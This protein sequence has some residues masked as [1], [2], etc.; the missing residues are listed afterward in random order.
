MRAQ[1]KVIR[2]ESCTLLL[3]AILSILMN[4]D[5]LEIGPLLSQFKEF[6][7]DLPSDIKGLA[8]SNS[9]DIRQV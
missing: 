9:D 3:L 5:G 6:T 2:I 1:L 4:I 8:I 7:R